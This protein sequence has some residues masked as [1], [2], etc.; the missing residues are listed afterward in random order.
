MKEVTFNVAFVAEGEDEITDINLRRYA[1]RLAKLWLLPGRK[2][3]VDNRIFRIKD[4][5]ML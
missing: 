1:F 5:K 3:C 4:M 2:V